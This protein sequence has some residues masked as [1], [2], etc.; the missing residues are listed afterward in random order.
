MSSIIQKCGKCRKLREKNVKS[1]VICTVYEFKF[2]SFVF[3]HQRSLDL[4]FGIFGT[5]PPVVWAAVRSKAVVLL[6][7]NHFLCTSHCLWGFCVWSL[8]C[9]ALHSVLSSFAII[10]MRKGE[11]VA[12]ALIVFLVSCDGLCSVAFPRSVWVGGSM[13]A[14]RCMLAR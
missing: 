6:F 12:I 3:K 7:L 14:R 8:F 10:L 5:P 13:M 11:L 9:Y 2:K 1:D 4:I